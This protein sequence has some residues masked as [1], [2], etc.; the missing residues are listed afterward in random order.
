[1]N[2]K[3]Y[4]GDPTDS[5]LIYLRGGADLKDAVNAA[6]TKYISSGAYS[7]ATF[8]SQGMSQV[9]HVTLQLHVDSFHTPPLDSH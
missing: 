9:G 7:W 6:A 8:K 2:R 3:A 1:M 4:N 5:E